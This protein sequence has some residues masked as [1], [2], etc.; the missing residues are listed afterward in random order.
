MYRWS[1]Y[2]FFANDTPALL[3]D[4]LRFKFEKGKAENDSSLSEWLKC[5]KPML[6]T[7]K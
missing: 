1:G 3:S 2:N 6:G 4:S 7:G 5:N